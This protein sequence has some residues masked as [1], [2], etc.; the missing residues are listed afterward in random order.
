MKKINIAIDGYSACGKSSTAKAVAKRL[1]YTYID[2][3]AMYRA[4]TYYLQ[5]QRINWTDM[6]A[7]EKALAQIEIDFRSVAEGQPAHTFLNGEDVEEKIRQPE[8]A[9]L[10]S[11]VSTISAVRRKLVE[12]QQKMAAQKGGVMD[13]RDIASVVIPD[14]E[15]KFF[16]TSDLDIRAFRRQKELMEKTGR[17]FPLEELKAN[18]IHRDRIDSSRDDSPLTQVPGAIVIDTTN[19]TLQDQI[20]Q[21][22]Q[23]AQATIAQ[24][25]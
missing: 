10:V 16:M 1:G 21:I 17:S 2:T 3:G 23:L 20:D 18:L 9:N 6:A 5:E 4:V 7:V 25:E 22:V 15:L 11:E 24:A 19:L 8:V 13:G 12:Q 14:A